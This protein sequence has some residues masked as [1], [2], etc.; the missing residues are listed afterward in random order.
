MRSARA[1]LPYP[2]ETSRGS[3]LVAIFELSLDQIRMVAPR[4]RVSRDARLALGLVLE[5]PQGILRLP[6]ARRGEGSLDLDSD[7][8]LRPR[9]NVPGVV[10]GA[11]HLSR[12]IQ[13]LAHRA[14]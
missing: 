14:E 1:N 12:V 4:I 9:E 7:P 8:P 6:R 2:S 11:R 13:E 3:R 5:A 10:A